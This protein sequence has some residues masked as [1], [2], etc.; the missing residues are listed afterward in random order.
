MLKTHFYNEINDC[1]RIHEDSCIRFVRVTL[2]PSEPKQVME[3]NQLQEL[4]ISKQ[5]N[6]GRVDVKL[7]HREVVGY[8]STKDA[9][10][11]EAN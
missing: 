8:I 5:V 1:L 11:R 10:N 7:P 6:L 3:A 4:G 2:M 9:V